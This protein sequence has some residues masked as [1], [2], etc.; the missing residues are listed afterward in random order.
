[1]TSTIDVPSPR[2]SGSTDTDVADAVDTATT[3]AMG[4]SADTA[5]TPD[6]AQ[7]EREA[8]YYTI[9]WVD[10]AT[11]HIGPNVRT[12]NAV[13]DKNKVS[14]IKKR[15]VQ[16]PIK[17]Y[18]DDAGNLVVTV[19]QLRTL[20]AV[21]AGCETVPV[22]V[23]PPPS[24]DEKEAAIDRIVDQV[25]ENDLHTAMTRGDIYRAHQQ[26]EAFGLSAAAIARRLSRPKKV[27]ENSLRVGDSELA[28][29]AADKY[30]LTLDQ[31]A[32]IAEF[33]NHGDLDAAKE[34]ILTAVERPNNFAALAQ[35]RRNDHAESERMRAL[36]ETLV[37]D[38]T[39]AGV[40]ILESSVPDWTGEARSLDKLRATPDT[41][42]GTELTAET[43][44]SC[45]GHAAWI[46]KE[47]DETDREVPVA[48][49]GC[50]DFRAHGHALSECPAGQVEYTSTGANGSAATGDSSDDATA[51]AAVELAR[52]Q[53]RII[54]RWVR[55]NNLNW[56]AA[57]DARRTWLAEF[58]LRKTAPKGTQV[59]LATQKATGSPDLRRAMER[60]HPLAHQLL[61]LDQPGYGTSSDLVERIEKA[62]AA[63]A[64]VYDVFL[65][66]AA[67][68]DRLQRN[69]W[70]T[71]TSSEALYL[72]TIIGWGYEASDIELKMLNPEREQDVI[73]AALGI[74]DEDQP[75]AEP[76]AESDG[77][78]DGGET[79]QGE[80]SVDDV[81]DPSGDAE[82]L[83]TADT[84]AA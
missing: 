52:Q 17:G 26:L 72:S 77:S 10:P 15:G 33:E 3:A 23:Q 2:T 74:S 76:D 13:P 83:D 56:D 51:T 37:A 59:F 66:L 41:E 78:G 69:A 27:V 16:S 7:A 67:M 65:T 50:V 34:L 48:E 12:E 57:V 28:A 63:K 70:R 11:L 54:N 75:N 35:R 36:T 8:E 64:T 62:T 46:A 44:A 80:V 38:L 43:H 47:Y 14:D 22:W 58:A 79:D 61:K 32:V 84:V 30:D 31:A 18:R 60:H 39:G 6:E 68:E 29:K 25:N 9:V 5:A 73:A 82:P 24:E 45:P 49:Y 20:S 1:V 81:G 21:K 42:P 4:E 55:E 19:G 71:P 40:T 53:G